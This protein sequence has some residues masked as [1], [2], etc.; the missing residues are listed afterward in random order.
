MTG[1]QAAITPAICRDTL[2]L[3]ATGVTVVTTLDAA[4]G[5]P[6][7]MTANAFMSVSLEPPLIVVSVRNRAHLY[8]HVVETGAYG[9][10]LLG[11]AQEREARRF[12]GMPVADHEPP[13]EFDRHSR[14]PVLRHALAWVVARV[15]DA[16]PAG[17]HTLFIGEMIDLAPQRPDQPPLAF[18]RST[19]ARVAPMGGQAPLPLEPWDNVDAW[20]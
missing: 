14:I 19:F 15:I 18:F 8:S 16:H 13:P 5:E 20:G 12:A 4:R 9:V 10:S 3:F 7:G 2:G 6:R 1:S 11:E 17:D